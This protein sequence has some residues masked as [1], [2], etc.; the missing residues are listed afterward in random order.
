MKQCKDSI[1]FS[2][3]LS[4]GE[5]ERN[6]IKIFSLP[7]FTI[8]VIHRNIQYANLALYCSNR[9]MKETDFTKFSV[10]N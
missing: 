8:A 1:L 6:W 2:N 5:I 10:T 9:V 7:A 3:V 4:Y